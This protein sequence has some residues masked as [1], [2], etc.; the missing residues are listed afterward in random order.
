MYVGEKCEK[1]KKEFN[2]NIISGRRKIKNT[3][4]DLDVSTRQKKLTQ[5]LVTPSET[6]GLER[7]TEIGKIF[8]KKPLILFLVVYFTCLY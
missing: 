6:S 4:I 8:D 5:I 1:K 7:G 2:M 3:S